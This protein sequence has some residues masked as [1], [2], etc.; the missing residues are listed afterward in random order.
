MRKT[1]TIRPLAHLLHLEDAPANA[2]YLSAQWPTQ[3]VRVSSNR[4]ERRWDHETYRTF[5]SGDVIQQIPVFRTNSGTYY[6]LVLT[7][8]DLAKVMTGTGET[9]QFL[10]QTY[11]TGTI[12]GIAGAVVTGSG[13][14]W[15][16]SGVEAGDKF[17]IDSDHT[18]DE[19]PD[20]S[21][22]EVLSVDGDTQ[23][24]LTAAY[25]GAATTGTYKLR[26]VYDVPSGE[27]W[28]YASVGGKFCFMNGSVYAQYWDGTATYA[29]DLNMT[30]ANQARHCIAYANRL[31]IA[32]IYSPDDAAR[33]PCLLRWSE[34]GDPSDFTDTTA[35]YNDFIDTEDPITGLGVSGN[36]IVVFKKNSYYIGYQTGTATSAMEFPSHL[37]GIGLY[38]PHSLTHVLGTC[39]WMGVD[40]FYMLNGDIAQSIGGPVR[41]KFFDLVSDDDLESVFCMPNPRYGEVLWVANTDEGQ[42]TFAWN[43]KENAWG[44]YTFSKNITGLGSWNY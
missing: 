2:S 36:S 25:G 9:Y 14:N 13:T 39:V 23:I 32:D 16:S 11:V 21:W 24:T 37:K 7:E 10:T 8:T 44:P 17:I 5:A 12:T 30:Y 26:K 43:Y 41:K 34:N 1:F 18:A 15:N 33:N 35:G 28:S 29:T 42:Y 31:V 40:D 38:A 6:T 20:A 19:E 4:I 22:A 3:N 27:R